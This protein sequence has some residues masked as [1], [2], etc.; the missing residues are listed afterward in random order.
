MMTATL[1][2]RRSAAIPGT[3]VELTCRP[4]IIAGGVSA[5]DEAHFAQAAAHCGNAMGPFSRIRS[6]ASAAARLSRR[7]RDDRATTALM[8]SLPRKR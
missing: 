4:A 5:L 7:A 1:R 6:P 2:L 3:P 8:L